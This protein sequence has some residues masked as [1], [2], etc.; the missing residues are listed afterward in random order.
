M[1]LYT[2]ALTII[3]APFYVNSFK[4]DEQYEISY[5]WRPFKLDWISGMSTI[6]LAYVS[7][8]VYFLIRSE[9]KNKSERRMKKFLGRALGI[10]C[11]LYL[12]ISIAGY[13][14]T[15]NKLTPAVWSLR[16]PIKG[17]SND[18]FMQAA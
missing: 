16:T 15:G 5:F 13:L 3:Q 1:I 9:M 18:Y 2:V 17:S 4:G 11:L 12:L 10:E 6:T 7:H 8:P 14:S